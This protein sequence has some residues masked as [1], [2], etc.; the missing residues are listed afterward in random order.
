MLPGGYGGNINGKIYF[1]YGT[2][3]Q[4]FYGGWTEVEA[5]NRQAAYAAF[6]AFHPAKP[7]G[8]LP[9]CECYTEEQFVASGMNGPEG[10][11]GQHCH[12]RISLSRELTGGGRQ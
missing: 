1:T 8:C 10:N 3:G 7:N 2:E 9:F 11:F 6:K 12:E 4:P 5:P